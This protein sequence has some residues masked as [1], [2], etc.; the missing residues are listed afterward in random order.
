MNT[1]SSAALVRGSAAIIVAGALTRFADVA[2]AAEDAPTDVGPTV[3]LDVV[4]PQLRVGDLVFIRIGFKPFLEVAAATNT[5][6]NHVGVVVDVNS[7]EPRIGESAFPLSRVTTLSRFVKRSEN[8]RFAVMRLKEDLTAEQEAAVL[9][10]ATHRLGIFYDTGFD[11]H[12]RRESCSRYAREVLAEA[13]GHTV[14]DVE[15]F[16]HLLAS[17]PDANQAFWRV[18]YLGRSERARDEQGFTPSGRLPLGSK[19]PPLQQHVCQFGMRRQRPR[20]ER[21]MR[22]IGAQINSGGLRHYQPYQ[23]AAV[24]RAWNWDGPWPE[25]RNNGLEAGVRLADVLPRLR[26][27]VGDVATGTVGSMIRRTWIARVW[28]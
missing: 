17:R 18:W 26:G 20:V 16:A 24:Q 25:L 27:D 4:A 11:L 9:A 13:T 6:T 14:G 15:T 21:L 1:R 22:R 3:P 10:A 28:Q 8:D 19:L 23:R 2:I 12:S 5:W 7:A